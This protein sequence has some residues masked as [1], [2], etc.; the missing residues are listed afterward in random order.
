MW[1]VIA[2]IIVIVGGFLAFTLGG[3]LSSPFLFVLYFL[4]GQKMSE[5]SFAFMGTIISGTFCSIT[6]I[7]FAWLVF[8]VF[9]GATS[10]GIFPFLACLLPMLIT[11]AKDFN[12]YMAMKNVLIEGKDELGG[13]AFEAVSEVTAPHTQAARGL[14]IGELTGI[15]LGGTIFLFLLK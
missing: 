14:V 1:T 3:V 6:N 12:R 10:F 8:R 11:I 7:A 4:L 15:L 2:Y 5:K 13:K 9:V